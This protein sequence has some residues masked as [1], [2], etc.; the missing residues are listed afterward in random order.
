MLVSTKHPVGAVLRVSLKLY[1]R[2]DTPDEPNASIAVALR[3]LILRS[4]AK[5]SHKT[6]RSCY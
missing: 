3:T 2:N 6:A 4:S 5:Y 1:D